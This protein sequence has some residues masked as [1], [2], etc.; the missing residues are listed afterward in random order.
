M[1]R[2]ASAI[3]AFLF[4]FFLKAPPLSAEEF[5][6][7]VMGLEGQAYVTNSVQTHQTLKEGDVLKAG[8][9]V[10]VDKGGSLDIAYDGEWNNVTTLQE[11]TKVRVESI[12]P[13]H[14][15]MQYGGVYAKLKKLPPGSSFE[16]Q[17]PTAIAAVRGSEYLA[18]YDGAETEVLNFHESDVSV[19]GL[20]DQGQKAGDPMILKDSQKTGI[21]RL[22][23]P[24]AARKISPIDLTRRDVFR[25]RLAVR[26]KVLADRRRVGQIQNQKLTQTRKRRVRR[27]AALRRPFA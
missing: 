4:L 18:T 25:A 10:E 22:A 19:W 8:D 6:C 23:R 2:Y 15:A 21:R 11:N 14:L 7:E 9:T 3:S 27:A 1:R 24:W 12:Y 17:T 20:D 5:Q 13:I 26:W 16:I